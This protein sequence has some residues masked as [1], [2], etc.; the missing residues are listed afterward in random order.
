MLRAEHAE[1]KRWEEQDAWEREVEHIA[2]S[3]LDKID[4]PMANFLKRCYQKGL[5][6][7]EAVKEAQE[8]R[9]AIYLYYLR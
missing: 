1:Q 5:S 9:T 8:S 7:F 2:G 6:P 3:N 4:L